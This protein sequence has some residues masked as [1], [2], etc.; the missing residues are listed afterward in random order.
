[1]QIEKSNTSK[2]NSNIDQSIQQVAVLQS[3]QQLSLF[4]FSCLACYWLLLRFRSS[5]CARVFLERF[6]AQRQHVRDFLLAYLD[7]EVSI[8]GKRRSDT[9]H[10]HLKGIPNHG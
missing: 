3:N 1:M 7:T 5:T 2:V 10:W 6:S 4:S 8:R 9:M